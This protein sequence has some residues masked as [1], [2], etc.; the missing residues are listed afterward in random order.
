MPHLDWAKGAAAGAAGGAAAAASLI[1]QASSTGSVAADIVLAGGSGAVVWL[2]FRVALSGARSARNTEEEWDTIKRRA[3][4]D[5]RRALRAE[6]RSRQLES[7]II[8][9]GHPLP[10]PLPYEDDDPGE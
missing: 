2:L 8:S 6:A 10:P 4:T 5:Y 7:F 9:K 1:A 3:R